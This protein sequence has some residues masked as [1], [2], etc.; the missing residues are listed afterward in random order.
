MLEDRIEDL[1][2]ANAAVKKALKATEELHQRTKGRLESL[3]GLAKTEFRKVK[4]SAEKAE[5]RA[6][7]YK[8]ASLVLLL[9]CACLSGYVLQ[10]S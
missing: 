9:V 10:L 7:R 4:A 3:A 2:S 5:R 1:S 8:A 6:S